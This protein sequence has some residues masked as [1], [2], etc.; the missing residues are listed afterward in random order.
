MAMDSWYFVVQ[1]A[2]VVAW[3]LSQ[4]LGK[5][6]PQQAKEL[7]K[8][9]AKLIDVRTRAEFAGGHIEGAVN[10]PVQEL[11]ERITEAGPKDATY[12][13]YC[14]SGMRSARAKGILRA[15]GRTNVHDLGSMGRW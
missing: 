14:A 1:I 3:A 6:A 12:V 7:V 5:V 13:V 8:A 4:R 9:G 10:L 15:S 2:L 11:E